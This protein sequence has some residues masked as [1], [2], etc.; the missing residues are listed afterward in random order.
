MWPWGAPSGQSWKWVAVSERSLLGLCP[1]MSMVTCET[2]WDVLQTH[3][4]SHR[5]CIFLCEQEGNSQVR[6]GK[7]D[8]SPRS[9]KW[10]WVRALPPLY[11]SLWRNNLIAHDHIIFYIK[12]PNT[13]FFHS[14]VQELTNTLREIDSVPFKVL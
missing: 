5:I 9:R 1:S 4:Q 3:V 7:R 11:S 10:Q 12:F 8:P 2:V 6:F 13:D 14:P